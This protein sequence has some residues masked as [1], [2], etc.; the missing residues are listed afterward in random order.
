MSVF[1][2]FHRYKCTKDEKEHLLEHLCVIRIKGSI[3]EM[4]ILHKRTT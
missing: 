1:E 3:K 4:D 2:F